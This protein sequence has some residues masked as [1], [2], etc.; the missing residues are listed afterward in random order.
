MSSKKAKIKKAIEEKKKERKFRSELKKAFTTAIIAAFGFIAALAWRDVVSE[1][2]NKITEISPVQ[3]K[4]ITALIVTF[5]AA[6]AI[7]IIMKVLPSEG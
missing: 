2:I 7:Y 1:L 5:L 6:L 3:G 4:L